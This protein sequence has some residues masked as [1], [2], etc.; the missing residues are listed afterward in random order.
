MYVW[1]R[2]CVF[3]CVWCTG[4]GNTYASLLYPLRMASIMLLLPLW[5]GMCSWLQMLGLLAIRASSSEG[6]SYHTTQQ[7]VGGTTPQAQA[8][9]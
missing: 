3:V 1:V 7:E 4:G 8:E 6:K 5:A 9:A 2:V